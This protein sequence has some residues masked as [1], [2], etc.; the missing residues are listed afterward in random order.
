MEAALESNRQTGPDL[1]CCEW[2]HKFLTFAVED[3]EYAV[4]VTKVRE[5]I[6][7]SQITSLPNMPMHIKGVLNLRGS[8]VPIVDLRLKHG[9]EGREYSDRTCIVVLELEGIASSCLMGV[10]VD[11]VNEVVRIPPET[12]D[13][14]PPMASHLLGNCI[15]GVS[16]QEGRVFILVDIEKALED[17]AFYAD[18]GL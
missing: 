4:P 16:T 10:V 12:V 5:I 6:G 18:G 14:P 1:S 9:L 11:S 17:D 7:V 8:V 15:P 13:P 2:E 3:E